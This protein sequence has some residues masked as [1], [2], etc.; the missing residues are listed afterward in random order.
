ME[1]RLKGGLLGT[2]VVVRNGSPMLSSDLKKVSSRTARAVVVLGEGSP[3]ESDARAMRV[4]LGLING[5]ECP[6]GHICVEVADVD[7]DHLIKLV[8][9]D[10]TETIVAHEV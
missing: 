6:A 10:I 1:A 8:G 7:A 4:V 5:H 2:T 3:Q 9:G